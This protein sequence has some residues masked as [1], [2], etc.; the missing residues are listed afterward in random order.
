MKI[1]G[2]LIL[3]YYPNLDITVEDHQKV[4]T[5]R[6]TFNPEFAL[7][8]EI[9]IAF[10]GLIPKVKGSGIIFELLEHIRLRKVAY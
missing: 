5:V 7:N 8:S 9:N 2:N 1:Q 4:D 10:I 3:K 6:H